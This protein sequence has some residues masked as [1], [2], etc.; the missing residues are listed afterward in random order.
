[1]RF[2]MRETR[3]TR[4]SGVPRSK[5]AGFAKEARKSRFL[6]ARNDR[7][8]GRQAKACRGEPS[9]PQSDADLAFV[10]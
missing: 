5:Q 10:R 9:E 8:Y 1:M 2:S 3:A 6:A 4:K 7:S